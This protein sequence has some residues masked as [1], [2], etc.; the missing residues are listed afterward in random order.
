MNTDIEKALEAA[1]NAVDRSDLMGGDNPD[2]ARAAVV[3]FLRAMPDEVTVTRPPTGQYISPLTYQT[4]NAPSRILAA[5]E[6]K[7]G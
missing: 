1:A 5:I 2:F 6:E 4:C 7:E 3:A